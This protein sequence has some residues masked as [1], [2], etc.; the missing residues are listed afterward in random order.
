MCFSAAHVDPASDVGEHA[1]QWARYAAEIERLD[2]G[3]CESDL[4][5]GEEAAELFLGD[6]R[7]M[8]SPGRSRSG[9]AS[10]PDF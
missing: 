6:S 10:V 9:A 4:P 5:V 8:R 3:R 2:Q 7:S 1:V